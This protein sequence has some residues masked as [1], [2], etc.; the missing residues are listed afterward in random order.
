MRNVLRFPIERTRPPEPDPVPYDD[1]K[2]RIRVWRYAA[3]QPALEEARAALRSPNPLR[4]R[5]ALSEILRVVS[6]P[7]SE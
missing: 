7:R 4:W 2:E 3:L 5:R 6:D 1:V